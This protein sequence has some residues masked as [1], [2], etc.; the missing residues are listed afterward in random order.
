MRH[1]RMQTN[2]KD[3]EVEIEGM[4]IEEIRPHTLEQQ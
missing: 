1:S 4:K 3:M 2:E